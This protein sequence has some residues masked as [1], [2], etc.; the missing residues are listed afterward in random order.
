MSKGSSKVT[1]AAILYKYVGVEVT[2]MDQ[3]QICGDVFVTFRG[4][5]VLQM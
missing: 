2:P 3:G 4:R 1:K 5:P